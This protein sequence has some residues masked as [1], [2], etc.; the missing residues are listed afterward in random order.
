MDFRGFDYIYPLPVLFKDMFPEKLQTI[1]VNF[2]GTPGMGF[3]QLGKI[4]FPLLQD[5]L[6]GATIKMLA[7]PAHSPIVGI[8]GFLTFAL[9]L[10]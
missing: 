2:N 5:Q 3:H 10:E 1:A 4:F 9:K 6:I 8:G 7:D